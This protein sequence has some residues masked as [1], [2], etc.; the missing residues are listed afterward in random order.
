M[1]VDQFIT[2]AC[3]KK[4][5]GWPPADSARGR[6]AEGAEMVAVNV[7]CLDDVDIASLKLVPFDGRSL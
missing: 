4:L 7:R 2:S 1:F 5:F 3:P 6:T